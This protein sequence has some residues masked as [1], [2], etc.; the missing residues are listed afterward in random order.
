MRRVEGLSGG[1]PVAVRRC[2]NIQGG[3]RAAGHRLARSRRGAREENSNVARVVLSTFG[4]A[5]DL[6]PFVALGLRLRERGHDVVF[7]V[8]ENFQPAVRALGFTVSALSGDSETALRPYARRVFASGNAL[9]SLRTLLRQYLLPT[10]P[11]KIA[12]LCATCAG[13]DLLVAASSQLAASSVVDLTGVPWAS[14]VV[15]P[16]TLPSAFIEAMPMPAALPPT[17]RTASNRLAWALGGVALR[18]MVDQPVNRIRA[19]FGLAPRRD[20][21]WTGNLSPTATAVAV[22][23]AF[24]SAP[25]DWPGGVHMTGFCFWDGAAGWTE[26]AEL[27]AFMETTD[28]VVAVTAGSIAPEIEDAF[29][30]FFYASVAGIRA[31]GGRALVIGAS[32]SLAADLRGAGVLT[33]PFAPY[34]AVFPRCA[35]VIHHG[36]IG[37]VAQCLRAGVPE[38]VVP[39]GL[40]Q[41]FN[42]AQVA[43]LGVG[44]WRP[45]RGFTAERAAKALGALLSQTTYRER[46]V[47]TADAIGREDGAGALCALVE[48]GL[49]REHDIHP[50]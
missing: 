27:V 13:A 46:A 23:P 22:S 39:G 34:S 21:L 44:L 11:A 42:A 50:V 25:P 43:R 33:L 26:P 32:P 45:R 2:Y 18:R 30:P 8:E 1:A 6:N 38:L 37:T 7:A 31:R 4:S 16:S 10:L 29:A 40:D 17:L 24:L 5:G 12:D 47:T 9:A 20:L 3:R 48:T 19:G 28:P 36:G 35:A 49:G 15:G 41:P 14:V